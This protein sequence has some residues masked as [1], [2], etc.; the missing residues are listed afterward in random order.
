M[1]KQEIKIRVSSKEDALQKGEALKSV[2]EELNNFFIKSDEAALA[3]G[4]ARYI[5]CMGDNKWMCGNGKTTLGYK[6]RTEVTMKEAIKIILASEEEKELVLEVGKWYKHPDETYKALYFITGISQGYRNPHTSYGFSMSGKW[7]NEDNRNIKEFIEA[8]EAEVF[9]ALKNEA[10]KR[11]FKEGVKVKNHQGENVLP[12]FDLDKIL[13][14]YKDGVYYDND[15]QGIWL[16]YKGVWSEIIEEPKSIL[17]EKGIYIKVNNKREYDLLMKHYEEKGWLWCS[18]K[19]PLENNDYVKGYRFDTNIKYSNHFD[20]NAPRS[21]TIPFADFAKEVGIEVPVFVMKSEDGVDLY[22]GD[23]CY[24]PQVA[25]FI[26]QEYHDKP[27]EFKVLKTFSNNKSTTYKYFSCKTNAEKWIKEQNKPKS[28]ELF[29]DHDFPVTIYKD[30]IEFSTDKQE[31]TILDRRFVE[32]K[33]N[34]DCFVIT[35]QELEEIY[36]AYKSL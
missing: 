32:L 31:I 15:K 24:V 6:T 8:T 28:I 34:G 17:D 23:V 27:E 20:F 13:S 21:K 9:E 33:D 36:Q 3:K 19:K 11:G 35:P 1:K 4:D 10:I 2:G 29:P 22:V 30:V 12:H 16:C 25:L 26:P 14:G 18:G 5:V 7:T